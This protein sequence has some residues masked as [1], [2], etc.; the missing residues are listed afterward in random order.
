MF[1]MYGTISKK[2]MQKEAKEAIKGIE[3]FFV[4]HPKRRVCRTEF[5]YGKV[6]SIKPKNVAE[7]V[8]KILDEAQ[9]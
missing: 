4:E 9:G 8:A 5:W 2:Q 6:Y 7:Q 1:V 3:N